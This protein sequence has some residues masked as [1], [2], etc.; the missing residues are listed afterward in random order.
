MA[1][2]PVPHLAACLHRA[3]SR[4]QQLYSLHGTSTTPSL[5][6]AL[7]PAPGLPPATDTDPSPGLLTPVPSPQITAPPLGKYHLGLS[8]SPLC[9]DCNWT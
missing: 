8:R 2:H 1:H 4:H 3:R 7:G 9:I 6:H 5:G